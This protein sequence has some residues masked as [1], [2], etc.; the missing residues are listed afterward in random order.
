MIKLKRDDRGVAMITVLL[1]GATLTAVSSAA[2]LLAVSDLR[3]GQEDR[4]GAEVLTYADAGIDRFLIEVRAG[5]YNFKE[6]AEAGCAVAPLQ[7]KGLIG[8]GEFDAQF[9]IYDRTKAAEYRTPKA[10]YSASNDTDTSYPN[11]CIGRVSNARPDPL[12]PL[13]FAITSTGTVRDATGSVAA[14]RVVRQ[15]VTIGAAPL[16][17]GIYAQRITA[18]GTPDARSVSLLTSGDLTGRDRLEFSGNDPYYLQSDFYSGAPATPIPAAAHATGDVLVRNLP[19]HPP[20]PNC[21]VGGEY[22]WDGSGDGT[23]A[24][25]ACVGGNA[26]TSLFTTSQLN[27]LVEQTTL[28][29]QDFAT[30]KA[31]AQQQGLYCGPDTSSC[32]KNGA[33]YTLQTPPRVSTTDLSGVPNDFVAYFDFPAGDATTAARTIKWDAVHH[34]DPAT[35]PSPFKS[36]TLIVRNG[37]LQ[38]T[39]GASVTGFIVVPEGRVELSGSYS[40]HG[41]IIAKEISIFG[42]GSVQLSQCWLDNMPGAEL[43]A[44]RVRWGEI[45]R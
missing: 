11:P 29:E 12:N 21:T 44:T 39:S 20:S 41:T 4:R 36:V 28:S 1:V 16:P 23:T 32:T 17:V 35:C 6:L 2:A 10:P 24:G 34:T 18:G 19:E 25:V 15:L 30:L 42:T 9:T 13:L 45:D 43:R 8:G 3:A 5:E 37:S 26:P 33:A 40:V 38:L 22:A 31:K 7:F 27:S 14:R